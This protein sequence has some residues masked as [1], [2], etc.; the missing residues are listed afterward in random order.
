M[1]VTH[2]N[3][4]G[5]VLGFFVAEPTQVKFKHETAQAKKKKKEKLKKLLPVEKRKQRGGFLNRYD[6]AYA[7]RDTVNQAVKVAP[8]VMK[9]AGNKINNI[10]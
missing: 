10:A 1:R 4:K 5:C 6:F 3:K 9:N 7:G 8:G 2:R